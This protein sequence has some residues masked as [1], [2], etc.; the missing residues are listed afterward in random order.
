MQT[1]K[2]VRFAGYRAFILPKFQKPVLLS[3]LKPVLHPLRKQPHQNHPK[4]FFLGAFATRNVF[5]TRISYFLDIPRLPLPHVSIQSFLPRSPSRFL[6]SAPF[7][8][9]H[10]GG[11]HLVASK[12]CGRLA[13]SFSTRVS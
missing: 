2:R 5:L 11:L 3:G 1:F 12:P 9:T 7:S 10:S 6:D 8:P 13:P 4:S